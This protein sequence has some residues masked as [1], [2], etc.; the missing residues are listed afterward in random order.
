M[1]A[2]WY[3]PPFWLSMLPATSETSS[4]IQCALLAMS[5]TTQQFISTSAESIQLVATRGDMYYGRACSSLLPGS[6]TTIEEALSTSFV[7]WCY[8][9]GFGRQSQSFIHAHA[10]VKLFQ[11][12]KRGQNTSRRSGLKKEGLHSVLE[13][14]QA[15]FYDM[16]FPVENSE[17]LRML[18]RRARKET[19]TMNSASDNTG[20][21][22]IHQPSPFFN[23]FAELA[24]PVHINSFFWLIIVAESVQELQVM[25]QALDQC[26]Y[27]CALDAHPRPK[28]QE[29]FETQICLFQLFC[30]V[31]LA[32]IQNDDD[33]ENDKRMSLILDLIQVIVQLVANENATP[34]QDNQSAG[35]SQQGDCYLGVLGV[36]GQKAH[37]PGIRF[38]AFS[39]ITSHGRSKLPS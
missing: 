35:M 7:L 26:E 3:C 24:N 33:A 19:K 14:C 23:P 4:A 36:I 18:E 2:Q 15:F 34:L 37:D 17:F 5:A 29:I 27:W 21:T 39:Q 31:H 38:R 6:S 22:L 20:D 11:S 12:L 10:A 28:E 30:Q 1:I 32:F 9:L 16:H 8:D 25:Q 13:V